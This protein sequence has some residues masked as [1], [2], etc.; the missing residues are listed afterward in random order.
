[1]KASAVL[2]SI[3]QLLEVGPPQAHLGMPGHEPVSKEFSIDPAEAR[4]TKPNV[5]NCLIGATTQLHGVDP[6]HAIRYLLD[7]F[8]REQLIALY[9]ERCGMNH[10]GIIAAIDACGAT[11]H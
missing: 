10:D 3:N 2:T 4:W 5:I 7:G 6:V 1:M 9:N 8:S 11:R